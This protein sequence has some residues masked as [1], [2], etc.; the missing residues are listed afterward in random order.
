[1]PPQCGGHDLLVDGV[2]STT[3]GGRRDKRREEE[4]R[5]RR[6]GVVTRTMMSVFRTMLTSLP[7]AQCPPSHLHSHRKKRTTIQP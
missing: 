2:D 6:G 1:M 4:G 7:I 5:R 3:N